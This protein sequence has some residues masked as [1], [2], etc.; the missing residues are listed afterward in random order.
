[1][2]CRL[3]RSGSNNTTRTVPSNSTRCRQKMRPCRTMKLWAWGDEKKALRQGSGGVHE[4]E[5]Q[6]EGGGEE[7][8]RWAEGETVVDWIILHHYLISSSCT[9]S[10]WK[11]PVL[12]ARLIMDRYCI[13]AHSQ[14]T[15]KYRRR[16]APKRTS[17]TLLDVYYDDKWAFVV[18]VVWHSLRYRQGWLNLMYQYTGRSNMIFRIT[19]HYMYNRAKYGYMT[20]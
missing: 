8:G 6:T 13:F 14:Q 5:R 16:L 15:R 17:F 18:M 11:Q 7:E 3:Y 10:A 12:L 4:E 9:R 19:F 20:Q 1:M 2:F